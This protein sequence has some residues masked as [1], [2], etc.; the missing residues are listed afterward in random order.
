MTTRISGLATT[1]SLG[2]LA[3]VDDIPAN[4]V[5]SGTLNIARIPTKDED[6]M[7]SDSLVMYLLNKVLKHM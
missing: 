2:D 3:L 1:S 4:K 7:S 5:V 6:N